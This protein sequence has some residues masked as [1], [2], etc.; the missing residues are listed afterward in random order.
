VFQRAMAELSGDLLAPLLAACQPIGSGAVVDLAGG[1][2][3]YAA[4]IL[5]RNPAATAQVWD[6]ASA[7]PFCEETRRRY[8]V[9]N[10][11]QF[12]ECDLELEWPA[13]DASVDLFL[14][15]HCLHHFPEELVRRL[16][17]RIFQSLKPGGSVISIEPFL[18]DSRTSPK[19][20]AIFSFYMM[21][22]RRSARVHPTSLIVAAFEEAGLSTEASRAGGL[23]D[24]AMILC[25]RLE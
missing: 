25:R 4:E 23:E 24:D 20:A 11:M 15:T 22:N 21:M 19:E 8:Q 14:A 18:S 1:H 5:R 10:R 17:R 7:R 13:A 9:E 3:Q 12:I 2:G 16:A 6:L